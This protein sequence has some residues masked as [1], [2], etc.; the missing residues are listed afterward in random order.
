[1]ATRSAASLVTGNDCRH[2]QQRA[3][4]QV[5]RHRC[6]TAQEPQPV[7]GVR[8]T[9]PSTAHS[10]MP[11]TNIE[12][13]IDVK[14]AGRIIVAWWKQLAKL[15]L[16]NSIRALARRLHLRQPA[17]VLTVCLHL[18]AACGLPPPASPPPTTPTPAKTQKERIRQRCYSWFFPHLNCH[19]SPF[20]QPKMYP[21]SLLNIFSPGCPFESPI[22]EA[23]GFLDNLAAYPPVCQI[24]QHCFPLC[25]PPVFRGQLPFGG[26][27]PRGHKHYLLGL[28]SP[29]FEE[30]C[31]S[32][33]R[34][35]CKKKK[36]DGGSVL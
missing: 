25:D 7:L 24:C 22:C 14:I 2:H 29:F 5:A 6:P 36:L 30:N 11:D 34:P 20:L 32:G 10:K 17:S 31:P 23:Y 16:P 28:L 8:T 35:P 27:A 13:I 19:F 18:V 1:M 12:F 21:P 4:L 9:R 3:T 33:L 26:V 15:N